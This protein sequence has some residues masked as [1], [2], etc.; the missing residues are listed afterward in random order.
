CIFRGFL[1]EYKFRNIDQVRPMWNHIIDDINKEI[2][3]LRLIYHSINYRVY[4]SWEDLEAYHISGL[5]KLKQ[6][7]IVNSHEFNL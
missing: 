2:Q 4:R 7:I 6:Q 1:N 3:E 5:K